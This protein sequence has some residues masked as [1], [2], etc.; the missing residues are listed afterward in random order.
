M[1]VEDDGSQ[2]GKAEVYALKTIEAK[3]A[4]SFARLGICPIIFMHE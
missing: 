4:T 2:N 1:S 3:S